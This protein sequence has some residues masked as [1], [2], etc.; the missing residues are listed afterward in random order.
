[1]SN[2]RRSPLDRARQVLALVL[3]AN[4]GVAIA[5][6]A[7]GFGTGSAAVRADGFHSLIDASAN[8]FGLIALT[9][10]LRPPDRSHTYGH[11]KFETFASLGIVM[12][13]A[14]LAVEIV[15]DAIERLRTGVEPEIS[16][17]VFIVMGA[18]IVIN[19]AV[20]LLERRAGV[21]LRSDF[22]IADAH[23]TAADILISAG[24]MV[25]IGL[26]AL[27][28]P[29]ADA[30]AS[31]V[32]AAA[33]AVIGVQIAR[34]TAEVLLD[35]SAIP[36]DQIDAVVRRVGGVRGWH[37]IRTRGRADEVFMDLHIAVDPGI[38]VQ[39]GH[40]IAHD[41]QDVI[42]QRFPQVTDV[43]VHVEPDPA[44]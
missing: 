3:V 11:R 36:D 37:K 33:V 13:L 38:S 40:G 1:M 9:F 34:R 14:V 28:V 6:V 27:G 26:A 16:Q 43:T 29:N 19:I 25:G 30:G 41:L 20:T 42:R 18:T 22:L 17:V 39:R 44:A 10:A 5:K 21:E 23:Q 4:L 15:R 35:Q 8:G 32:V 7:A 24:V 31:L 12:L 2:R